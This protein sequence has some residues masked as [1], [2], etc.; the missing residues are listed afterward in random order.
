LSHD[1]G[2]TV[3]ESFPEAVDDEEELLINPIPT[4]QT[5]FERKGMAVQ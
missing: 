2:I 4:I 5:D 1:T 3:T